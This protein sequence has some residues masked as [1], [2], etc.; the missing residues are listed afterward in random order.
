MKIATIFVCL[1]CLTPGLLLAQEARVRAP[2]EHS[3]ARARW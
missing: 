2:D 3:V 1:A